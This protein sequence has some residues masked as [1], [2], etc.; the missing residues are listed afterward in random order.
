MT[1]EAKMLFCTTIDLQK[2]LETFENV[3]RSILWQPIAQTFGACNVQLST[4]RSGDDSSS[5]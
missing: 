1:K 2:Q 4:I 3:Q 5:V